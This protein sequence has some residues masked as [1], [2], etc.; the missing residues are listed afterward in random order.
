MQRVLIAIAA[1]FA[2]LL[3]LHAQYGGPA[4]LTRGQAPA[5]M[6]PSQIDF[7]PFLTVNA[8]YD[9]G[10]NG[11]AIDAN[12]NPVVDHG[13]AGDAT[14]GVSG[15]H[16][17]KHTTVGLDYRASFRHYTSRTYYDGTDQLLLFSVT[18]QLSRHTTFYLR[19][20]AGMYSQN[21]GVPQLQQTI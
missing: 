16:S 1:V 18:H 19:E 6:A 2:A 13:W 14:A 11:V 21:Y 3:P 12:G 17:W 4:V 5:A 10:L 8:G 15:F 7:R 9:T 20:N